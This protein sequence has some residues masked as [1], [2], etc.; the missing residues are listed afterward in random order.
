MKKS[1]ILIGAAAIACG[2][3]A[4]SIT[5]DGVAQRWP[6][7]NKLDITYTVSGGQDVAVGVYARIVFTANIGG[8]AYTIDG[9]HDVGASASEG[10]HTVTWTLPAGLRAN[11]CTISAQLLSADNPSGDDY[12]VIDL[13]TGARSYEGVL[14]TQE[15]SNARYNTAAY[16]ESKLVL[17]KVPRWSG[18]GT[19]PNVSALASLSGYPTGDD[20]NFST[21][22]S[23]KEWP[24]ER[25]YYIG[26]FMV[27]RTQYR[28]LVGSIPYAEHG[29]DASDNPVAHRPVENVS[30][31]ALRVTGTA[32]TAPIP[33]VAANTGTF[34]QRLNHKT[35]LCFDLPTEVMSEIAARAGTTTVFFWG[36]AMNTDYVVC[37]ENDGGSLPVA[38]GLQLPNAWGLYDASGNFFEWCLDDNGTAN[39]ANVA[40]AFVP[41]WTEA[42]K[43]RVRGG[44]Q[45]RAASSSATQFLSSYRTAEPPT[46]AS[47]CICFRVSLI[48]D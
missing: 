38:V 16:K 27:T 12:L 44:S 32:P 24:I 14:A 4:S 8:T 42:A 46:T 22:N 15:A 20:W 11:G 25:D 13:N 35:G 5:V 19:L 47:D 48:A 7:N 2:A 40:D 18:R 36:N 21:T 33:A 23:R 37:K 45:W 30:W 43:R 39:L 3:T 41:S 28:T 31:N 26:V 17:R 10:T 29:T 9:V 34:F 1:I 6:W